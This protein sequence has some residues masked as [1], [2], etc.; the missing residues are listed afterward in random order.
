MQSSEGLGLSQ[1]SDGSGENILRAVA[2]TTSVSVPEA[3]PLEMNLSNIASS[4]GA[5]RI[6]EPGLLPSPLRSVDSHRTQGWG[7]A[8][9]NRE[10]LASL[11]RAVKDVPR[12]RAILIYC[13]CCPWDKCPNVRPALP[14]V[15]F[16][17]PLPTLSPF[18]APP[19]VFARTRGAL[20]PPHDSH[21][22]AG[23]VH[24]LPCR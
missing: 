14:R 21:K 8:R 1:N 4:Y 12:E 2:S 24:R 20:S 7:L 10:G 17:P 18:P 6:T 19:S 22:S 9:S 13:G 5:G 23:G 11:E 3:G 16:T 15:P